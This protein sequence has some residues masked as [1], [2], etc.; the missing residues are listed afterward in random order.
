[1]C[2]RGCCDVVTITIMLKNNNIDLVKVD[3]LWIFSLS[4]PLVVL[5]LAIKRNCYFCTPAVCVSA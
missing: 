3:A 5:S 1:M 4:V 2:L